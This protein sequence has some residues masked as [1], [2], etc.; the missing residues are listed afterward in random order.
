MSALDAEPGESSLTGYLAPEGFE[1][2]LLTELGG[3]FAIAERHGRLMIAPGPPRSIAW[4]QN[5]WQS[6]ERVTIRSIGHAASTLRASARNWALLSLTEHRRAALVEG[7][8]PHVSMKPIAPYAELPTAPLG[9]WTLL[10]RDTLLM[11]ARCSSPFPHGVVSFVED[12][13]GP[14]SRAY[15]KLWEAF[16]LSRAWPKPGERV[17]DLGSAPGGWTWVLAELGA[18]VISVD[19]APLD[20]RVAS[21]SNVEHRQESAFG[22]DPKDFPVGA[23]DWLFSDVICYPKRL[24]GLVERWMRAH[25]ALRFVCTLKFQG[26]TDHETARAFARVEG[27]QL[28]HLSH[29]RHELTWMKL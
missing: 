9:S 22:L 25:P 6:P 14:P 26:E 3:P 18:K 11:S 29:N 5:V 13:E 24:L 2:D 28:V 8:L 12:R 23:I 4:S 19:K 15:L 21:R 7:K 16:T 10:D 27:S 1:E 20:P 17:L